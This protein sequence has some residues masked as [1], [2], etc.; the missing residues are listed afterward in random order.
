MLSFQI[1][2]IVYNKKGF[3]AINT[4]TCKQ[5]KKKNKERK[6]ILLLSGCWVCQ[7]VSVAVVAAAE[8]VVVVVVVNIKYN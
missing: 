4:L 3:R 6:K 1:V 5:V 8:R 7:C 2:V